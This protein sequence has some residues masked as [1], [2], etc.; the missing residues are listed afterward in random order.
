MGKSTGK[1]VKTPVVLQMEAAECGAASLG[2][3]LAYYKKYVPLEELRQKCGVSRDGSK[4]SNVL[5]AAREYGFKAKG[6]RKEPESLKDVHLPAIIHWNFN[7]F[8]VLEGFS[9][10]GV[11]LNDPACGRRRV[12]YE[13]FDES[14]TGVVLLMQPSDEFT[15]SGKKSDFFSSLRNRLIGSETGVLFVF[16]LGLALVLPGLIL[17]VF[18]KIFVD[19]ILVGARDEWLK[20]LL[21]G[22]GLTA[23]FR[24]GLTWMQQRYLLR[25]EVK[26]SVSHSSRFIWH[27]FKLPITFFAARFSG[28]ISSRVQLNAEIANLLSGQLATTILNMVMVVFYGVLLMFYDHVLTLIGL[29]IALLNI[30]AL[31]LISEKRVDENRLL[32][33]EGGKLTGIAMEGLSM[34]ETLK[35]SGGEADFFER[36]SGQ[37]A[38]VM[39]SQQRLGYLSNVLGSVPPF[40]NAINGAVILCL[41]GLRVMDGH[42]TMGMLVAYQTLM[43]SFL[44]P[45]NSL[46]D[47]GGSLQLLTGSMKRLDDV[48]RHP[49]AEEV[50]STPK[51]TLHRNLVSTAKLQ[52]NVK[53][54]DLSFGYSPLDPPL[55]EGFSLNLESGSR[56]ALVG[57]SGSGKS[58]IAKLVSGLYDSWDGE[59]LFD[60]MERKSVPRMILKNSIAV[61]DQDIML[62][63]GSIFENLCLWDST[64]AEKQVIQ[65]AKDACIHDV[66]TERSGGY[67]SVI[68]EGGG[69]FSGGQRQRLE[70]ARALVHEPTILILDEATSA[71]DP[72]TE[73][74]VDDN[75]RRRGCTCIIVAHRLST[76]RDC[77][78]IIVLERGK[79]VQR[80]THQ[81]LLEEGGYYERLIRA[82]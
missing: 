22:M 57:G 32:L 11:H 1:P 21:L 56:V 60:E 67:D 72:Q 3:I 65:A 80:G 5:K 73:K 78:E 19:D 10:K 63:E 40:L 6:Y 68:E 45:V 34:M 7:H 17:P 75:L 4:A 47:L 41:G 82:N 79:V 26:L 9:K 54:N 50:S 36:W 33:Q 20:P 46:V 48:N 12:S 69:N 24:A 62:Y 8:L 55:I 2:K 31:R 74:I 37:H 13:D 44:G 76:I 81:S 35:A 18:A 53:I 52:G 28:D 51:P 43:Q 25:L 64:I 29:S 49:L 14:F 27:V 61:V 38:K 77:D 16:L 58:T 15:P 23:L 42:F 30:L 66:I 39:N 71:L 59:I 70:I